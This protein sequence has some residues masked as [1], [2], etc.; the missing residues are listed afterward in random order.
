VLSLGLLNAVSDEPTG[1]RRML[2]G[3]DF[4]CY[5]AAFAGGASLMRREAFDRAGGYAAAFQGFGEEFDLTVRLYASGFAVLHFPELSMHHHV[6]K[7]DATWWEQ[8]SQGY[9][10]LQY[11]LARLYPGSLSWAAGCKAWGTQ[12]YVTLRLNGGRGLLSDLRGSCA[13]WARGRRERRAVPRRALELLYF[14]KYHRVSDW[15]A[16]ERAP[17]GVLWRA[18]WWRL[19]RKLAGTPKLEARPEAPAASVRSRS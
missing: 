15:A 14:A 16:L 17:R 11:T 19:R 4:A 1:W 2:S 8:L 18:P 12:A 7:D 13:W 10:H 6:D 9:Q 5:H 3:L